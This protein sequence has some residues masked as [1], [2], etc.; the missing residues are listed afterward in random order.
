MAED[1]PLKELVSELARYRR[2]Y[3]GINPAIANV[4]VMGAYPI[5]NPDHCLAML[6]D[7]L[8]VRVNRLLPWWV[9]LEP[10]Q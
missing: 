6:E 10:E 3:L 9:T 8:P 2:G 5:N 7:A 1:I 4:R